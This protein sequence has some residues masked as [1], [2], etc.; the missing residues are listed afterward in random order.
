MARHPET[1]K[2]PPARNKD[3]KRIYRTVLRLMPS[4]GDLDQFLANVTDYRQRPLP[5][6][7]TGSDPSGVPG[8]CVVYEHHDE[9]HIDQTASPAAYTVTLCHEIFHLFLGHTHRPAPQLVR[10]DIAAR[11]FARD[12][13]TDGPEFDSE[14]LA[15]KLATEVRR[16]QGLAEASPDTVSH[17]LR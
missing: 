17:R 10:P 13:Y 4:D 3:C 9:I 11:I 7:R 2:E 1:T 5:I 14:K 15:T 16:R 6:Y 12:S 8:W